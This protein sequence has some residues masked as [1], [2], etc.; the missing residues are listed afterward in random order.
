MRTVPSHHA[1]RP[2]RST[3]RNRLAPTTRPTA[4]CRTARSRNHQAPY[5]DAQDSA[6]TDSYTSGLPRAASPGSPPT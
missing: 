1:E 3:A 6:S 5:T 2:L 4:S